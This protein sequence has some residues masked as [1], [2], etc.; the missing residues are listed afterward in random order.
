MLVV[1]AT[2]KTRR[3]YF[4]EQKAIKQICRELRGLRNR[5]RKVIRTGAT[6][7]TQERTIQPL[8]KVSSPARLA[9]KDG[10]SCHHWHCQ[11]SGTS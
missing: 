6:D 2:A 8:P 1:E 11:V 9:A 10:R 5:V 4:L 7:L 3:A